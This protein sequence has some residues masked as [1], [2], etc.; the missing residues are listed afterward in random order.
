MSEDVEENIPVF[1]SFNNLGVKIGDR[2]I[3]RNV[4]GKVNPGEL[5]AVMGPSG[6]YLGSLNIYFFMWKQ[7]A[8]LFSRRCSHTG[9]Q[10]VTSG[11]IGSRV[12][13]AIL[14]VASGFLPCKLCPK[15]RFELSN[16]LFR[17]PA[18]S[19]KS[20]T[21]IN[22]RMRNTIASFVFPSALNQYATKSGNITSWHRNIL[23]QLRTI[24][25]TLLTLTSLSP[26]P[27]P[28][29]SFHYL[30]QKKE[31]KFDLTTFS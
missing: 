9:N 13:I 30:K 20:T 24:S 12:K 16:A 11:S 22:E 17:S 5:L 8:K 3:L 10:W 23:K 28:F 15:V 21:A 2:E 7:M 18:T 29:C 1:L 19:K 4:S 26:G 27:F 25:F 14:L 6:K 31:R